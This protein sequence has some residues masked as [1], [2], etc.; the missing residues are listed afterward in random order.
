MLVDV[1]V[2]VSQGCVQIDIP[3]ARLVV[4]IQDLVACDNSTK[5]IVAIGQTEQEVRNDAPEQMKR[6]GDRIEFRPAFDA[7]HF[8]PEL[9]VAVLRYYAD[10]ALARIRPGLLTRFIASYVDRFHYELYLPGYESLPAGTQRKVA[11][12]LRT[13][14]CMRRCIINGKRIV[15]R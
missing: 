14:P 1:Q 6:H 8:D 13:L 9:A 5:S 7:N 10:K 4:K 12:Y 2:R 3:P 15:G 11:Q